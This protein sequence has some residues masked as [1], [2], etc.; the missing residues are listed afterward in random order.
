MLLQKQY[1]HLNTRFNMATIATT[2]NLDVI[3]KYLCLVK[4][5]LGTDSVYIRTKETLEALL[6]DGAL[7]GT[8]KA[9][10]LSNVL[11]GLSSSITSVAM[12]TA[13]QWSTK[14]KE[15]ELEKL[16]LSKELD[17]L[18]NQIRL[19]DTQVDKAYHDSI[20]T[21]ANTIRMYGTPTV[22]DGTVSALPDEGKIYW[23]TELVKQQDVNAEKEGNL[24][25]SKLNE[26]YAAI[27]KVVADTVTNYGAWNYGTNLTESGIAV[28]P[29]RV[30]TIGVEPLSDVQR[31]IAQEQANGYAYNAWA[32]AATS[33]SSLLGTAL[34][35]GLSDQTTVNTLVTKIDGV[36]TKLS[37]AGAPY[38][39]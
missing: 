9:D 27:H 7:S 16:K 28:A 11:G 14:E 39:P 25:D 20:A 29:T 6:E 35:G 32:N 31:N 38:H 13:L 10:V 24:I 22:V 1:T 33:T 12:S 23:D 34:A 15:I 36:V 19:S 21:Q 4:E 2:K 37:S 18:D 5:S 17:I 26:S 3:D 30:T 8:E